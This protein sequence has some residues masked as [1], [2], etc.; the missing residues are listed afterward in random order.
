MGLKHADKKGVKAQLLEHVPAA[1]RQYESVSELQMKVMRPIL[2]TPGAHASTTDATQDTVHDRAEPTD[3][4]WYAW[5]HR[6]AMLVDGNVLMMEVPES[7]TS[8]AGY[9]STLETR[10]REH[11][12]VGR[13]V[14]VVFDEPAALTRAKREEQARRDAD[15]AKRMQNASPTCSIDMARRAFKPEE[16]TRERIA[17]VEDV[18]DLK[19]NRASRSRLYDETM[20]V[21]YERLA[22]KIQRWAEAG[23]DAGVLVIDGADPCGCEWDDG[24]R[25]VAMHGTDEALCALLR[26]Q[27]P[28]GEGDIKLVSLD[29][30]LRALVAA[31]D[32]TVGDLRLV[33][34]NT[35][36]TDSLA[37]MMIDAAK[38]SASST[39]STVYSVLC[40]RQP[41]S[42]RDREELGVDARPSFLCCD[43]AC[44]E[45]HLQMHL[46]GC[47]PSKREERVGAM[48]MLASVAA[49]CGCDFTGQNGVH[50][51]RFDHFFETLTT[52]VEANWSVAR[53]FASLG[54]AMSRNEETTESRDAAVTALESLCARASSSMRMK[55]RYT[56]QAASVASADENLLLRAV[57]SSVYWAQWE[58]EADDTWG[59]SRVVQM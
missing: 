23:H 7:V 37:I 13:I 4:D 1:F 41:A 48:L 27:T 19:N 45:E 32:A 17:A 9:C 31:E 55:P 22:E 26:R 16:L 14:V 38:Q 5:R 21:V 57:W 46:F 25:A 56:R 20:R 28:V 33:V 29:G 49:L 35:I 36:D 59:F 11:L 6:T 10:L 2:E 54:S 53:R 58:R 18:H 24:G 30:R 12:R 15:R 39:G 44:L 3:E 51:S 52:D 40:M 34:T 47:L 42:K 50:G 43:T 8:F